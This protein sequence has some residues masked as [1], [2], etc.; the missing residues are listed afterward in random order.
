[1]YDNR[2]FNGPFNSAQTYIWHMPKVM[3]NRP[4]PRIHFINTLIYA[5]IPSH[6]SFSSHNSS[7][8]R[9]FSLYSVKCAIFLSDSLS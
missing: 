5:R 6:N 1:M 2:S 4:Y 9:Y 3:D 7:S 8:N